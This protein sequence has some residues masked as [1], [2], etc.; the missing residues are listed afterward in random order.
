MCEKTWYFLLVY[1]STHGH[2]HL[3]VQGKDD[4]L[5]EHFQLNC[6]LQPHLQSSAHDS[7]IALKSVQ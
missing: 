7:E 2:E 5:L 1:Q 4:C 3:E 6:F